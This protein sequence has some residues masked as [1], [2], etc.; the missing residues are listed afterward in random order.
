MT[1]KS[2]YQIFII[3][4]ELMA[5]R[6]LSLTARVVLGRL[7]GYTKRGQQTCWPTNQALADEC[8]LA[9]HSVSNAIKE[10]CQ[11]HIIETKN[12]LYKGKKTRYITIVFKSPAYD[13]KI[14]YISDSSS[15]ELS[16][17]ENS[18]NEQSNSSSNELS[19]NS[20]NELSYIY[21]EESTKE[22]QKDRESPLSQ[23]PKNSS[24]DHQKSSIKDETAKIKQEKLIYPKTKDDCL[25]IFEPVFHQ[26]CNE[27]PELEAVDVK[28]ESHL[29]FNHYQQRDWK[30]V[31]DLQRSIESWLLHTLKFDK[32]QLKKS[33]KSKEENA[34]QNMSFADQL[35][36]DKAV[37][38]DFEIIESDDIDDSD[39]PELPLQEFT[40]DKERK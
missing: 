20:S 31:G 14:A 15:N 19:E 39:A 25:K 30:Y 34:Q 16:S 5:D 1:A 11:R 37:Q 6:T 21:T 26:M 38:A 33:A 18:I 8:G 29:Y 32:P 36:A 2:T 24:L 9:I 10:L 12:S 22:V 7:G 40:N 35:F 27:H 17:N 28:A 3:A 13:N 23:S 4:P